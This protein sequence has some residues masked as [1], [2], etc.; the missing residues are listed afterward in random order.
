MGGNPSSSLNYAWLFMQ[1]KSLNILLVEDSEDDALIIVRHVQKGDFDVSCHRVDDAEQMRNALQDH[2]WDICITD[3]N[4]PRFNSNAAL[5]LIQELSKDLPAIIV[6]GSIGEDVAV[7]AMKSGAQDYIMKDNLARLVPAIERA[8]ADADERLARRQA[9]ETIRFLAY[10]DSLTKLK[11]RHEYENRLRQ[12]MQNASHDGIEHTVLYLDLDQFKIINDTCGHVA[13]DELLKAL[14]DELHSIVR[15]GDTLARL[16]GD[17]F[18]V[19]LENCSLEH[20]K[21]LAEKMLNAV[22]NFRFVR[23]SRAFSVGVS[24]GMV[25]ID[26]FSLD[27]DSVMSAAD[28]ACYE[29]KERGRNCIV[30]YHESDNEISKRRAEMSWV[31]RIKLALDSDAFQI[32]R[33]QIK[34]ISTNG[35]LNYEYFVRLDSEN[36]GLVLPSVFMPAAERYNLM[37]AIDKWVIQQVFRYLHTL[38]QN[39]SLAYESIHFINLSG[40]S[41]NESLFLFIETMLEKYDVPADHICFEIT[42]TVAV[43]NIKVTQQFIQRCRSIGVKFALDDFGTGFCSFAYLKSL[44]M[45]F[46]KIDGSFVKNMLQDV[47]DCKVVESVIE[48]GRVAGLQTIAEFVE[49]PETLRKLES[50]G[51]DYVQGYGVERPV[52]I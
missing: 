36:D 12:A 41:L 40:A 4:L 46:I 44:P 51:I 19:L 25:V 24:I 22:R 28:M 33:Q 17:E 47:V 38:N 16:G 49:Q 48:I 10:H 45:D 50:L 13:G 37:P 34:A 39:N 26:E 7:Q 15:E 43:S 8:L 11:N 18:G 29:A 35:A 14:A 21:V 6:S 3:H 1:N 52:P 31:G 2:Q 23:D 30:A 42:E 9:E 32:H 20:A 5:A 27:L